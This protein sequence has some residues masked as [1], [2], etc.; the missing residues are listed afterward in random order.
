MSNAHCSRTYSFRQFCS[1]DHFYFASLSGRAA[2]YCDQRVCLSICL[3]AYLKK[4]TS[5]FHTIFC[6]YMLSVATD[7][8]SSDGNATGLHVYMYSRFCVWRHNEANR[9]ESVIASCSLCEYVAMTDVRWRS[10][11]RACRLV[12]C[13]GA[14]HG[15]TKRLQRYDNAAGP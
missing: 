13:P 4:Q 8:S 3:A 5:K 9:P 6:I 14:R 7:R 12:T 2:K 1:V 10:S 11:R 15:C